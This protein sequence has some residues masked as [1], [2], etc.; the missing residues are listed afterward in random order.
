MSIFDICMI[1]G[2]ELPTYVCF[3]L[4]NLNEN[5]SLKFINTIHH[6]ISP[7]Q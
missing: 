5:S 1:G 2:N 4:V 7:L 6:R 3:P